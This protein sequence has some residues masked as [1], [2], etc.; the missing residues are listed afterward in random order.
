[1]AK[2]KPKPKPK[3]ASTQNARVTLSTEPQWHFPPLSGGQSQGLNEAGVL[4]FGGETYGS[5]AREVLQNSLDAVA[6][7]SKP[8]KVTFDVHALPQSQILGVRELKRR[9]ESCRDYWDR[10]KSKEKA[11]FTEAVR[12]LGKLTVNT[13]CIADYNTTGVEGCDNHRSTPLH[14]YNLIRCSGS[15]S[16]GDGAAGSFG[17]G[18]NAPFAASRLRTIFYST[19]TRSSEFRFAGV[20]KLVT[21]TADDRT[22][23]QATGF[24]DAGG[25]SILNPEA[26]P[27][28][29]RRTEQGTTLH[30]LGFRMDEDWQ[31]AIKL[32]IVRNFWLAIFKGTLECDVES[33]SINKANLEHTIRESKALR[34]DVLPYF[35][36]IVNSAPIE[37]KLPGLG[38]CTLHL[39]SKEG[40]GGGDASLPKRVIMT[41]QSGMLVETTRFNS[42]VPF[43]GVFQCVDDSGNSVLRNMEPP[44]HDRWD[45]DLPERG[46]NRRTKEVLL[47]FVR[48]EVK[49]LVAVDT[50]SV[51]QLPTLS[52]FLPDV[53]PAQ[54]SEQK[55]IQRSH[56][57][58]DERFPHTE[59]APATAVPLAKKMISAQKPRAA[60]IEPL[61]VEETEVLALS[62]ERAL[63]QRT[64]E[65]RGIDRKPPEERTPIAPNAAP[66]SPYSIR[67]RAFPVNARDADYRLVVEGRGPATTPVVLSVRIVGDG[68]DRPPL[69]IDAAFDAAGKTVPILGPGRLGP[70]L[71]SPMQTTLIHLKLK[72]RNRYALEVSG[73]A[74]Q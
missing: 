22:P 44:A 15:S 67:Y 46:A 3:A 72:A 63:E 21:H 28:H 16:K 8:V 57:G 19:S 9:C 17:I 50:E 27:I 20:A 47:E 13:L 56:D 1:M 33:L 49:A 62:D 45:P 11:F 51:A 59:D 35:L 10:P 60:T 52:R 23:C 14:W 30:I 58:K 61:Q 53:L 41:R 68:R 24:F 5:L 38:A 32:A 29:F 54:K 37:A 34:D 39:L 4:Q 69:D 36:A 66:G 65:S 48:N 42:P 55:S 40:T 6:D 73:N 31:E 43:A 2:R 64:T 12:E 70:L 71:I 25:C 26:L 18:K 74:C 7:R